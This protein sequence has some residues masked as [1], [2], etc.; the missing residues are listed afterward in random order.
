MAKQQIPNRTPGTQ[1]NREAY[2]QFLDRVLI[3]PRSR[4]WQVA[5]DL[6]MKVLRAPPATQDDRNVYIQ[7]LN[8]LLIEPRSKPWRVAADLGL[9]VLRAGVAGGLCALLLTDLPA[10]NPGLVVLLC[11]LVGLALWWD[12]PRVWPY[13]RR[14]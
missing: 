11:G 3:E 4:H 2:V 1:D 8:R 10:E 14:V 12:R 5:A 7:F 13:R 6:G 9:K